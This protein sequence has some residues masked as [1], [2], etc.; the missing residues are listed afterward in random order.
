MLRVLS[1]FGV[2]YDSSGDPWTIDGRGGYF[3]TPSDDVDVGESGLTAR[4]AL[5]LAA[6]PEGT[7]TLVGH[8]RLNERPMR[9]GI[10]VL[11]MQGVDVGADGDGLPIT[12]AGQ[13]GLWGGAMSVDCSKSSQFATAVLLA[14]PLTT[15]PVSVRLEGLAGSSRYLD[16]TIEL[17]QAF[18]AEVAPNITGFEAANNGYRPTD[19]VIEADASAAVYPMV[20]AAITAGVVEIEGV[21]LGTSQPDMAVALC[22]EK[23]GCGVEST[24]TGLIV[25]ARERRLT[26]ISADMSEAPDGALGL[27]VACLYAEGESRLSGLHSLRYKESDRLGAITQELRRLGGEVDIDGESLVIR[28][29]QLHRAT[30][31]SHND[32]RMA[33]AVALVGLT[34][35]DVTVS[36][37]EVVSKTWPG[38]WA[39][40]E[41]LVD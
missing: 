41:S 3:Q 27:A 19:Y 20:A 30:V 1:G 13:G 10:D 26:P 22:L 23:M 14:A 5:I 7:T 12:V 25:D 33:M 36:R 4:I 16:M 17:M 34:V 40:L 6:F 32:H 9:E 35:D 15:E 28:G 37:P 8:G 2:P 18:G 21:K 39:A 38:Y 29:S 31:D 24:E 11:R